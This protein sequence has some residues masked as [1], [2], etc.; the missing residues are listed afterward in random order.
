MFSQRWLW[1]MR[2]SGM[3]CCVDLVWTDVSEERIVSIFR[4]EK[5]V[6][7][8]PPSS[9]LSDFSTLK[10]EMILSSGTSV[11]TRS[12]QHHIPEDD[13]FYL[14][15]VFH[16]CYMLCPFKPSLFLRSKITN[17]LES[18]VKFF[19]R[20]REGLGSNLGL[21]TGNTDLLC[22]FPQYLQG[23]YRKSISVRQRLFSFK[24]FSIRHS[25]IIAP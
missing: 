8:L 7:V 6:R 21:Y 12:T 20:I 18:G 25:H 1:R 22:G 5:S 13:I 15:H 23:K 19:I 17:G 11:H 16:S 2:F 4:V 9:S 3:W 24:S 14:F 10:M